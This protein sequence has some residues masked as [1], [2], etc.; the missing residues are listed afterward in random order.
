MSFFDDEEPK[1][2]KV[3]KDYVPEEERVKNNPKE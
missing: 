2:K 1:K 3:R